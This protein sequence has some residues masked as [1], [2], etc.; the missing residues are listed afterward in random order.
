MVTQLPREL[1]T[2]LR[3]WIT[4]KGDE[5]T[6][7]DGRA[8]IVEVCTVLAEKGMMDDQGCRRIEVRKPMVV[9]KIEY[10]TSS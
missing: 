7:E 8:F 9:Q 10:A 3:R 5:L 1:K 6:D 4:E 2:P